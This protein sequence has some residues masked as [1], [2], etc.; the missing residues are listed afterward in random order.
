MNR[1]TR[2]ELM[3]FA[4]GEVAP[5]RAL[6]IERWL[7]EHPDDRRFVEQLAGLGHL[8]R[9]VTPRGKAPDLT[10]SIFA[11]IEREAPVRSGPRLVR[12]A[13]QTPLPIDPPR[14]S[15]LSRLRVPS[16]ILVLA[17]AAA[18][19][20]WWRSAPTSD[21]LLLASASPTEAPSGS[22]MIASASAMGDDDVVNDDGS[23]INAIEFGAQS[24][25][26]FYVRGAAHASA[27]VWIDDNDSSPLPP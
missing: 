21:P 19:L 1:P 3:A 14:P 22:D 24:G 27:V 11:A 20:L 13:A 8:V 15:L 9:E 10:D 25:A 23:T 16:S 4:D 12:S 2:I 18:L 17:A 26:I 7:A 6:E 5:P